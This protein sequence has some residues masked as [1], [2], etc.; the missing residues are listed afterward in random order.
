MPDNQQPSS[1]RKTCRKCGKSK[2][3]DKFSSLECSLDRINGIPK[4]RRRRYPRR[5][6][7]ECDKKHK[8]AQS[9][10]YYAANKKRIMKRITAY[11]RAH[12]ESYREDSKKRA[13][14]FREMVIQAY[15]GPV[16]AC[17]GETHVSMMTL[18]H[19]NGGGIKHRTE[20]ANQRGWKQKVSGVAFYRYLVNQG[21]PPG[22]QVLCFNCNFSKHLLGVC[23]HQ[24]EKVRRSSSR[25]VGARAP[26]RATT[27]KTKS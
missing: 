1:E 3:L 26:K 21:F 25:G 4:A 2:S 6:C 13:R 9:R 12:P 8:Q 20:I 22:Y 16:C 10:V 11:R 17:C 7:I 24:S 15:G 5:S 27:L 18:D 14:R 19:I 23:A